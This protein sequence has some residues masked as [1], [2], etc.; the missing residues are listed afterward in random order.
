M[1]KTACPYALDVSGQDLAGEAAQLRAQGPAVQVELPGGVLAWAVTRHRYVKQ[2]LMDSRVSRAPRLHWPAL[3]EGQIA[4]DWPLYHWVSAENM[5]FSYGESHARLR[6][7]ISGAFTA[8]RTE[9]LRPRVEELTAALL[10]TLAAAPAGDPVDLRATFAKVLPMQVICELFGVPED[11][12]RPLISAIERT[13][14]TSVSGEE[15]YKAQMQVFASVAQ[16]VAHKRDEPGDDLTTVLLDIRDQ[17]E[18]LTE[19]ELVSTLNIMIG[20]GQETTSTL[21]SNA[22]AALLS[23]PEQ[24]EHV[25][26]GRA[27]WEDVVA[28]TLR[29]HNPAAYIPLRFAVEDIELDGITLKKGDP[30][31]VSF[32]SPGLDP[33]QYGDGAAV[34]DVLRTDRDNL[35]FGHGV[36]FCVGAN[37]ARMEACIA[38]A[39]LFERF[40]DM[41]L[42]C[43]LDEVAPLPTFVN[44]GY[45]AL[46]VLLGPST[47]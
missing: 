23:R 15:I 3:I 22:T 11:A 35:A 6:R 20:A 4:E 9:D 34:F 27:S 32:A 7:M 1:E 2:L 38:L 8:R 29:V 40:P 31:L 39:A 46:P 13:V 25:R 16:L 37:L 36:H 28:E 18:G 24:L 19:Q 12:R 42:A 45:G 44:N 5:L 10:D 14:S 21:I 33:E 47:R 30:I 17:G 26:A 43:S 41:T